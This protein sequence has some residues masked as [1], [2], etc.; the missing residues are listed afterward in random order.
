MATAGPATTL[1]DAAR[2]LRPR[3]LAGRERIERWLRTGS[4]LC[5]ACAGVERGL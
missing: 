2:A 5:V 1:L 4:G 3:I